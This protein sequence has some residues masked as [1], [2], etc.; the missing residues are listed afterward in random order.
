MVF[1]SLYLFNFCCY[2][3]HEKKF[4]NLLLIDD[5]IFCEKLKNV[6]EAYQGFLAFI[7]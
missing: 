3:S 5:D 1:N 7:A 2:L 4:R 6:Y